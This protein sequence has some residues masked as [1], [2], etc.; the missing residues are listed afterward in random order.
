MSWSRLGGSFS[1]PVSVEEQRRRDVEK[2]LDMHLHAPK[3]LP[4]SSFLDDNSLRH[5]TTRKAYAQRLAHARRG[6]YSDASES[7]EDDDIPRLL[8]ESTGNH[9]VLLATPRGK[10]RRQALHTRPKLSRFAKEHLDISRMA[11]VDDVSDDEAP[12][13]RYPA[14]S[15]PGSRHSSAETKVN[16]DTPAHLP[17]NVRWAEQQLDA[18]VACI[19]NMEREVSQIRSSPPT[20]SSDLEAL[21]KRTAVLEAEVQ[22][23]KQELVQL[24]AVFHDHKSSCPPEALERTLQQV[25]TLLERANLRTE[26]E[27]HGLR[28]AGSE[29]SD[30]RPVISR[31]YDE[32]NRISQALEQM[33]TMAGMPSRTAP[34]TPPYEKTPKDY[35]RPTSRPYEMG[36]PELSRPEPSR[37]E[38][39]RPS[40]RRTPE[41]A[42]RPAVPSPPS[43]PA[44]PDM[45]SAQERYE[46]VC[47]AVAE[48]MG[49]H[50][51]PDA[52]PRRSRREQIRADLRTREA[53]D[54]T[55]E[56]LLRRLHESPA[57]TLSDVELR[58]LEQVFEQHRREFLHQK[59]LYSEL[60]DELKR[61]EP[62][63][64]RTKRRILAG[65]L[66]ESIDS[67]E[68]EAT[69]LNDLHAHLARHGR[70]ARYNVYG[71]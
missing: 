59:T 21:A 32:L 38:P 70:V 35:W 30:V 64:D 5:S 37:P 43:E 66:H 7:S 27:S 53:A 54:I 55:T 60:A 14:P 13:K 2:E 10:G 40:P 18:L 42:W 26:P 47:R 20:K 19:Q 52:N 8:S 51:P 57:P 16:E 65:H 56:L 58:I 44:R 48:A 25:V 50:H 68:A 69:R 67:L 61:M 63:M 23:Q 41:A 31:L 62:T 29:A 3:R 11:R 39:A 24:S 9:T 12:R 4:S 36:M 22:S 15:P 34:L 1:I 17:E 46:Q 45:G 33:Q 28:S 71:S 6:S 49:L